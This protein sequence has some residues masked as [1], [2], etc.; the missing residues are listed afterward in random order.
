MA[1]EFLATVNIVRVDAPEEHKFLPIGRILYDEEKESAR[2]FMLAFT[3]GWVSAFPR[4]QTNIED[5]PY[6]HGDL[7]CVG[8][9]YR[10][11]YA[12]GTSKVNLIKQK[13]G[14]I[15]TSDDP[16]GNVSYS[17]ELFCIPAKSKIVGEEGVWIQL[18]RDE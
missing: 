6:L 7:L 16:E 14:R 8:G 3:I 2:L 15:I 18:E 1:Y 9:S 4:T 10:K 13:I 5:H 11:D 12:D 17:I